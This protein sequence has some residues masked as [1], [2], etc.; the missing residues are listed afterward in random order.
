MAGGLLVVCPRRAVGATLWSYRPPA[1]RPTGSMAPQ[2]PS[3]TAPWTEHSRG[4][5]HLTT[6][7][8]RLRGR[9]G[10]GPSQGPKKERILCRL[11][12]DA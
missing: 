4:A 2:L 10:A 8:F 11:A 1:A 6:K 9:S 12:E 5:L 7:R 3:Q